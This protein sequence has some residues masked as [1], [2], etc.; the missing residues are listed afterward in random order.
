MTRRRSISAAFALAALCA[1]T[2]YAQN[3]SARDFIND[4]AIASMAE[5]ELGRL[6]TSR[7]Q[8]AD[9]KA[10]GEM[11]VKDHTQANMDLSRIASQM[12]VTLPKD[13]DQK[14]KDLAAK[15]SK[16]TGA[17]FDREY[18]NAMV[19]GH[20]DVEGKLRARAA[21]KM[22]SATPGTS[23]AST[24]T[25]STPGSTLPGDRVTAGT[26]GSASEGE[27]DVNA[28][29]TKTLPTVQHHLT[30]AKELQRTVK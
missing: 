5:V 14:H 19:T 20:Q 30:R 28:W 21:T 22:T 24:G 3:T 1:S 23:A 26:S 4:M 7:A 6:A 2:L 12:N 18:V 10:F 27:R 29:A 13:L 9:V 17:A 16:L 11:M 15:L 8:S 25:S